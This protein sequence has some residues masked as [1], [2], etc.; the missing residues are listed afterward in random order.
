MCVTRVI[1]RALMVS[2]RERYADAL[3]MLAAL[4]ACRAAASWT[5]VDDPETI[6][7]WAASAPAADYRVQL[8]QRPRAGLELTAAKDVRAGAGF[9]VRRSERPPSLARARQILRGWLLKVV[10]GRDL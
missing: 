3:S 8:I 4:N 1:E 7:T 2:P 9:R 5:R 10:A 6:E